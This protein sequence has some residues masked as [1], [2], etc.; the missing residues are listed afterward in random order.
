MITDTVGFYQIVFALLSVA[1]LMY[2]TW[3]QLEAIKDFKHAR[4]LNPRNDRRW[5]VAVHNLV[6]CTCVLVLSLV[7]VIV[8]MYWF[9]SGYSYRIA[10]TQ[11]RLVFALVDIVP[12][13]LIVLSIAKKRLY[14]V[15]VR[16]YNASN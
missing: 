6:I 14:D 11:N 15:L 10:T 13:S 9:R 7:V 2:V 16:I 4:G 12:V 5:E 8:A 3:I 1:A